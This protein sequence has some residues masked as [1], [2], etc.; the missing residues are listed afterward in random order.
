[1]ANRHPRVNIL[2][3]GPGV[4]GHCI[5]VDPWFLVH[6]LPNLTKLIRTAREVNDSKPHHVVAHV[7]ELA[8]KFGSPRIGCLGLAY[9]ANVDDLRES[10]SL[11]IVRGLKDQ[12]VGELLVCDPHVRSEQFNEFPL[13]PLDQ[14]LE[15]SH[16]LVLLTDHRQFRKIPRRTLQE[17]VVV[18]TRG[19][20]R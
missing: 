7:A 6:C 2:S 12:S 1:L 15:E 16:I 18:D 14:V 10:P 17:R 13:L 20:W 5:S 11:E 4:G 3:P 9:K 19:V 8:S